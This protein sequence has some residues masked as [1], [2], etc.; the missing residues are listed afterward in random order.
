MRALFLLVLALTPPVAFAQEKVLPVLLTEK[1]AVVVFPAERVIGQQVAAFF[2]SPSGRFVVAFVE[3]TPGS[4]IG[5]DSTR[6]DNAKK[7]LLVW[8]STSSLLKRIELDPRIEFKYVSLEWFA[9]V[10]RAIV[11]VMIDPS[12]SSY[13]AT[14]PSEGQLMMTVKTTYCLDPQ[15]ASLKPVSGSDRWMGHSYFVL[16]PTSPFGVVVTEDSR[17]IFEGTQVGDVTLQRLNPNGSIGQPQFLRRNF[18]GA[19]DF[20]WTPDGKQFLLEVTYR[21]ADIKGHE[22]RFIK[23]DLN[24]ETWAEIPRPRDTFSSAKPPTD[25]FLLAESQG[26]IP[27]KSWRL[28]STIITEKPQVLVAEHAEQAALSPNYRFVVFLFKGALFV[29][30]LKELS[31]EE[32]QRI[33]LEALKTKVMSDARQCVL[34][35]LMFA[36]DN[37][38]TIP[39]GVSVRTDLMPY[40]MNEDVIRDFIYTFAG[41][42]YEDMKDP[43]STEV[44]HIQTQ[45][46]RAVAYADGHVEWKPEP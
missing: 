13:V 11:S 43:A 33:E 17:A 32:Y 10:E 9:R 21:S 14:D 19:G 44:G 35:L 5:Y 20:S 25:L 37:D 18:Q 7:S 15:S 41:G 45:Y 42:K 16:S 38:D 8:D 12:E 24:S 22:Q 4:T 1:R 39:A 29:E 3:S 27:A 6:S 40:I 34:G 2:I 36:A 23:F 46:G 28:K 30:R 26:G 31:L